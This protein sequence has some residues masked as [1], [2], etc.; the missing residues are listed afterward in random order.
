MKKIILTILIIILASFP[1]YAQTNYEVLLGADFKE[2]KAIIHPQLNIPIE[3]KYKNVNKAYDIMLN[4]MENY[5]RTI[6]AGVMINLV[7]G[8]IQ[9]SRDKIMIE[10][11]QK[12]KNKCVDNLDDP[13]TDMAEKL[14]F[15]LIAPEIEYELIND[16]TQLNN[17]STKCNEGLLKMKNECINSDYVALAHIS[18]SRGSDE[19]GNIEFIQKFPDHPYVQ[20]AEQNLL[21]IKYFWINNRDYN[22]YISETEKLCEKYKN[23]YLPGGYDSEIGLYA[24]YVGMYH[25]MK[26]KDKVLYY[27]NK[28]KE[29][30]PDNEVFLD[31]ERM[32]NKK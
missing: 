32:Y 15:M 30:A 23:C 25:L 29:K 31:F 11:Y 14:M 17:I 21:T 19:K 6:T 5:P 2:F 7:R 28:L 26:E 8:S 13:N 20:S 10:K 24:F 1:A 22:K 27:L 4:I 9:W 3:E 18:L 16:K 12:L